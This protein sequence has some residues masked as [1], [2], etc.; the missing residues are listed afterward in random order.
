MQTYLQ[1]FPANPIF[2]SK[3]STRTSN[4]SHMQLKI[5]L[6][7]LISICLL[8]INSLSLAQS[9][10]NW[11]LQSGPQVVL[12]GEIMPHPFAGGLRAPQWSPIDMDGDGDE[13]L[14]VFDRDGNRILVFER[15]NSEWTERPD[16][17]E[18]WPEMRHW[19]LLRDFDCDG[20]PDLF[21]SFQNNIHVWKNMGLNPNGAPSFE[22]FA[23]PLMASWDFGNGAQELPVI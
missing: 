17:S 12:E 16:W 9:P 18:G 10:W 1:V 7:L 6:S 4:L 8:A 14:F 2:A 19:A 21:T 22:P 23:I 20:L 15:G 13:D 3:K 11:Q 5:S